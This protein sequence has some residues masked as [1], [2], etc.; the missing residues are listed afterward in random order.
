MVQ[1]GQIIRMTT[2]TD[3][4]IIPSVSVPLIRA[5]QIREAN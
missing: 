3:G 4:K 2:Q 5:T 1:N